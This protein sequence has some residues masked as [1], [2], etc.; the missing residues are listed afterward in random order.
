MFGLN[1]RFNA[2]PELLK[3]IEKYSYSGTVYP[4]VAVNKAASE[5]IRHTNQEKLEEARVA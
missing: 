4:I 1:K 2:D 3:Y 5:I